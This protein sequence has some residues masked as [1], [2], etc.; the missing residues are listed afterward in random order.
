MTLSLEQELEG[1]IES[2]DYQV[3]VAHVSDNYLRLR[4]LYLPHLVVRGEGAFSYVA[5]GLIGDKSFMGR[6]RWK[7]AR[8]WV[9]EQI[10]EHREL[11]AMGVKVW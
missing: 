3:V 6:R 8:K 4:I 7:K 1:L 2:T 5:T 11:L 10:A 9:K